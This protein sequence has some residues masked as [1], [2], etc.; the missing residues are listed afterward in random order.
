[1]EQFYFGVYFGL[2]LSFRKQKTT[3]ASGW[4]FCFLFIIFYFS[5]RFTRA[6]IRDFFRDAVFFEIVFIFAAL[7]IAL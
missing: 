6:T 5:D 1:M 3:R 7:S 4:F 2:G